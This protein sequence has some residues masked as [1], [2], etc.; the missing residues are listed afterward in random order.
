L[1]PGPD[2]EFVLEMANFAIEAFQRGEVSTGYLRDLG[3]KLGISR[4][5]LVEVA[6]TAAQD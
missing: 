3:E 2:R 6:E 5:K 1:A 4:A